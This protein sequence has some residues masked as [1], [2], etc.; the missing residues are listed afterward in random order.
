MAKTGKRIISINREVYYF[1]WDKKN[2][3]RIRLENLSITDSLKFKEWE[4]ESLFKYASEYKKTFKFEDELNGDG[5]LTG[6]FPIVDMNGLYVEIVFDA[7]KKESA[8]PVKMDLKGDVAAKIG[9]RLN[10][11]MD[12]L[13]NIGAFYGNN[14]SHAEKYSDEY[15]K[16]SCYFTI[17]LDKS[18]G[19]FKSF[20]CNDGD[21]DDVIAEVQTGETLAESLVELLEK[22]HD[23]IFNRLKK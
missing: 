14:S 22:S 19:S 2:S 17:D 10:V 6:C 13:N 4:S 20:I 15:P 3:S 8:D 18:S 16:Q 9:K 11:A 21:C 5:V 1:E 7:I 12:K 23:E